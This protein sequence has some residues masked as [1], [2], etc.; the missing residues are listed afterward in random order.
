M[1]GDDTIWCSGGM[2]FKGKEPIGMTRGG[3]RITEVSIW[4]AGNYPILKEDV[5]RVEM[6]LKNLQEK[7]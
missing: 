6:F 1:Y 5:P 2:A 4:G 7:L 3:K